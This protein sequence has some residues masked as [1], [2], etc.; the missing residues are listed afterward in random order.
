MNTTTAVWLYGSGLLPCLALP[1]MMVLLWVY[2]HHVFEERHPETIHDVRQ[3][4]VTAGMKRVRPAMM[5]TAVAIIALLPVL[6]STREREQI[7]G[8]NGYSCF[9]RNDHPGDDCFC[10]SHVPVHVEENVVKHRRNTG[11][12]K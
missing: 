6:T 11:E 5:T 1:P 2:I 12:I 10:G 9:R 8:S 4:V 3:A 7:Y